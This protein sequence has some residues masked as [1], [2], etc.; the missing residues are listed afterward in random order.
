MNPKA[1]KPNYRAMHRQRAKLGGSLCLC[2][3]RATRF[4]NS[5][6]VCARCF[7]IETQN[8]ANENLRNVCGYRARG[9]LANQP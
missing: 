6:P 1:A 9:V 3:Q 5:Y 8:R 4:E 2:G 7:A